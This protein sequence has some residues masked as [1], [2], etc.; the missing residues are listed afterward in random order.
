MRWVILFTI[1][2]ALAAPAWAQDAAPLPE[3]FAGGEMC[4]ICHED[5]FRDFQQNPHQR[6]E[7]TK[8]WDWQGRS[9]EACHGAG[10]AHAESADPA[11]IF[12]FTLCSLSWLVMATASSKYV[13]AASTSGCAV[14]TLARRAEKSAVRGGYASRRTTDSPCFRASSTVPWAIPRGNIVSS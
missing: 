11:N 5:T 6:L 9:C 10:A 4:G 8:R 13:P 3:G 1:L 12:G 7:T 2:I 14:R